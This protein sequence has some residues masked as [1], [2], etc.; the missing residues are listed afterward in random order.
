MS[1]KFHISYVLDGQIRVVLGK[2]ADVELKL[3]MTAEILS[4]RFEGDAPYVIVDV[5]DLKRTT[6]R[7]MQSPDQL[8][9][10]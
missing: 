6:Y 9:T 7:A 8:L 3:E 5:S 2:L 10:Y 4:A 1:E